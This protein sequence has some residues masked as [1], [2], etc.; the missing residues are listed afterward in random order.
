MRTRVVSIVLAALLGAGCTLAAP[1]QQPAAATGRITHIG[2]DHGYIIATFPDGPRT[3]TVDHRD[4][5]R[6][7]V[8]GEIGLDSAGRPLTPTGYR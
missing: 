1:Q 8:G 7:S 2:F 3:I 6:Y 4:L 5:E